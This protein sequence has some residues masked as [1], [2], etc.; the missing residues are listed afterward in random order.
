MENKYTFSTQHNVLKV[1]WCWVKKVYS[2][3]TLSIA[4]VYLKYIITS[5]QIILFLS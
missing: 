4:I 3:C 1:Y 5:S 2:K